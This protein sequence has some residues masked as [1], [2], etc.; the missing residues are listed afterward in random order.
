[1]RLV[2]SL[3]WNDS[4][5]SKLLSSWKIFWRQLSQLM[6]TR[7][8]QSLVLVLVLLWLLVQLRNL[9]L[10]IDHSIETVF[11]EFYFTRSTIVVCLRQSWDSIIEAWTTIINV[12]F[13]LHHDVSSF[14][15]F[16]W[17][18]FYIVSQSSIHIVTLNIEVS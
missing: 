12:K 13:L 8:H 16:F 10:C 18:C 4:I 9:L 17:L 1:M 3:R 6:L 2:Y 15:S 14:L 11:N 5:I 7:P